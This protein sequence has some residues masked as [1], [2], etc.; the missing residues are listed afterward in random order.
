MPRIRVTPR[1]LSVF[2]VVA[3]T[4]AAVPPVY[5]ADLYEPDTSGIEAQSQSTANLQRALRD[6]GFYRGPIDGSY[7]AR[8]QQAVMAFRKE[9]GASRTFSWSNSLWDELNNY[10]MPWTFYRFDEPNRIEVNLTRQVL[11]LYENGTYSGVF[12]ISS[13]NGALFE[14]LSGSLI[15]ANTPTG[16]FK[17]RRH[18]RGLRVSYLGELWNPW[19]FTGGYAFHGSGSVP[20]YPASHGC[21]RL[22]MWDSDWL[23]GHLSIGMPVHVWYEPPGV[24]PVYGPGGQ[25]PAGGTPPC[26]D[27]VICDTVAFQD[28]GSRFYLWDQIT[29]DPSIFPFW[30]GTPGDVPFS[31]DWNGDGVATLGLYRRSN[32]Y[33][34]LRNSNTQGVADIAFY[35]GIPGDLPVAGDFD[36]DG[37]DT[38]SIYRPSEQRFYIINRLGKNNEGLGAA[39]YFFDFGVPGDK[40]FTGDFDGDGIDTVG[41]HRPTT[42]LVYLR[43]SNTSGVAE[44]QFIFGNPGD[45]LIA[46]DWNGDGKD[47]VAVFRPRTGMFY[48]K[49]SNGSGEAEFAVGVGFLSNVVGMG[50]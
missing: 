2:L 28:A 14:G 7:G 19:Y 22:P 6:K 11:Y 33:V 32:G 44:D 15:R 23:E 12:P 46:G 1:R 48:V 30:Y 49:N 27:G 16:D 10:V 45:K 39:E 34:Y 5:A 43:N 36:G 8:T 26:P 3:L 13:G 42:G 21:V 29:A 41:L 47:T 25:L 17:I 35:F 20:A 9:I 40:P 4:F 31:G 24:G 18:I 38:I 50:R 37:F